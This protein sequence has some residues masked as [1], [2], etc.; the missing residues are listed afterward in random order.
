MTLRKPIW[1]SLLCLALWP[2]AAYAQSPELIDAINRMSE[3]LPEGRFQEALPFAEKA[4]ELG[5]EEF[6]PDHPI[7][8]ANLNI[9]AENFRAQG[10]YAEAEPLHQRALAIREKALGPEHPDVAQSLN[11][12]VFRL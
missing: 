6:G 1:R 12:L 11:S 5:E 4:V 8:A 10:C 3:L 7:T 9:L 2:A